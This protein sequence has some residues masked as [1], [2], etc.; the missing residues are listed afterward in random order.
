MW[1]GVRENAERLTAIGDWAEALFATNVVYESLVGGLFRSHLVMQISAR[2]GDYVTPS[3][4]GTGEN[5]YARDLAYTRALFT[6][7]VRDPEHGAAN[8]A[9][10]QEWLSTWL[11]VSLHA[12]QELQ[13]I[14][15]HP[16]ER[17]LPFAESFSAAKDDLRAVLSDLDLPEPKELSR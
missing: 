12:A 3:L 11:P 6:L 14:W 15:S 7:L 16:A 10:L 13:P 5:D 8:R 4:V 1:Q 2:N 17:V 9:Q